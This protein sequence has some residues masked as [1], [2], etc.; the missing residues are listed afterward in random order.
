MPLRLD[1]SGDAAVICINGVTPADEAEELL[2][3]LRAHP[4][5]AVDLSGVEHL[6]TAVLQLL[7]T[8]HA[9]IAAWPEDLFWRRCIE[10]TTGEE[11]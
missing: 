8:V 6:H 2:A 4:G 9:P 7:L 10:G 3:L 5:T 11:H 1:T